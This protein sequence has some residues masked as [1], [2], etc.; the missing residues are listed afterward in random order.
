MSVTSIE[1]VRAAP[2]YAA[3]AAAKAGVINYTKTAALELAPHGIRVN[4]L[5]PDITMTEGITAIAPAGLRG[6]FAVT[7]PMGRAGH[8]DEMAGAAVFLA[9][10]LSSYI[11]GQTI[12]VDGGTAGGQ[13]LVPP[14]PRRASTSWDRPTEQR[15]HTMT[16][17]TAS[18]PAGFEVTRFVPVPT[19]VS[20]EAQAF[21]GMG[22]LF[23]EAGGQEPDRTDTEAWRAMIT[24]A[25]E[26]LVA[27]LGS[28]PPVPSSA[29]EVI[30][31]GDVPVVR[32]H[33]GRGPRRPRPADLPR[34][35]RWRPHHGRRRGLPGDGRKTTAMVRHATWSVDYRMPPDHPYPAALDD[36]LAVYRHLLELRPPERIVVGGGSAGGNLAAALM[37]RARDEG[38]PL[39]AALVLLTPEVDLTESGDSFATNLGHRHRA[40][41]RLTDVRPALR[42][43]PRPPDPYLSPLFGDFTP[44]FPP[45]FLQAGTRDLFL[46][47]TVRMHRN[48]P[49]RPASRP[50]CTSSRR[51]PT[52]GS[53]VHPRTTT[54][55]P[56]SV[57]SS[58]S[59]AASSSR[60][61]KQAPGLLGRGDPDRHPSGGRRAGSREFTMSAIAAAA[62]VSRPTLYKWF[63]TKERSS[64][65]S[66]PTRRSCSTPASRRWSTASGRPP[67]G[68]TPAI[69][70][71]SPTSTA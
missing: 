63:P 9:S 8:V 66:P 12:H 43:R 5:A 32:P 23:G 7:V 27:V 31:V 69:R 2:G 17:D 38:L 65:P 57:G 51:C 25:N 28:Q 46:S 67:A 35:P 19:S 41:S 47:N 62:G 16:D 22:D 34:H 6:R 39:P 58:P 30:A 54:S 53:S 68:S 56:R 61:D 21:L 42:R 3:Y 14:S 40:T 36:C 48:A 55:T 44:P 60:S 37:L 11:T 45:T 4:A 59:A 70:C 15:R 1:G 49:R 33:P 26:M 29:V 52:A 18:G 13:R 64:R 71:W 10:D 24:T 20:A 50:S